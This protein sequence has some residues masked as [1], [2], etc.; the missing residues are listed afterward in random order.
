MLWF[1]SPHQDVVDCVNKCSH[2]AQ[3]QIKFKS[4]ANL[5]QLITKCSGSIVGA[6]AVTQYSTHAIDKDLN[7]IDLFSIG[8][9]SNPSCQYWYDN[10]I[11]YNKDKIGTINKDKYGVIGIMYTYDHCEL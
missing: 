4:N 10:H 6:V 8:T 3:F 5:F 7:D 2:H 9:K 1:K 11:S